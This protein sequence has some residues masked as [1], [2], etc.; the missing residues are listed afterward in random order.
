MT[1]QNPCLYISFLALPKFNNIYIC[2]YSSTHFTPS[3]SV[4]YIQQ[5]IHLYTKLCFYVDAHNRKYKNICRVTCVGNKWMNFCGKS[6]QVDKTKRQGQIP[7]LYIFIQFS[8]LLK[9]SQKIIKILL[10]AQ[11]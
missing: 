10:S 9:I 2:K 8:C 7:S 5:P 1:I 3:S 4:S 11:R 6:F